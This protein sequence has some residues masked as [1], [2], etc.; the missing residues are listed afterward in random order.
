MIYPH[1][2]H[3]AA[4]TPRKCHTLQIA[5][6]KFR[7]TRA[8]PQMTALV[9]LLSSLEWLGIERGTIWIEVILGFEVRS[10]QALFR[11]FGH[12]EW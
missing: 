3:S 7:F 11:N 9:E 1:R 10:F 5:A 6:G 2:I 8:D 12:F 4:I